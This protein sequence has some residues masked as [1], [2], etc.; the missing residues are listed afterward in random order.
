M[1]ID[2]DTHT[3]EFSSPKFKPILSTLVLATIGPAKQKKFL[4]I[5]RIKN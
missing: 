2:I 1:N 5:I 3:R 4:E